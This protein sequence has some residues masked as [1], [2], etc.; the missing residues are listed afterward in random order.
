MMMMMM[1]TKI[2]DCND[3]DHDNDHDDVND[4]NKNYIQI[5]AISCRQLATN[6]PL[7]MMI[8]TILTMMMTMTILTMMMIMT[9]L[10]M[11]MVM[12]IMTV[13]MIIMMLTKKRH[14]I[15]FSCS[16]RCV[17]VHKLCSIYLEAYSTDCIFGHYFVCGGGGGGGVIQKQPHYEL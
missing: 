10:T 15:S 14:S 9:I 8:I 4:H 17:N 3:D 6:V 13:M 5:N 11:M 1:T 16:K 12:T 2:H 7:R